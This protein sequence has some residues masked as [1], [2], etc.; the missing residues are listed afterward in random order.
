MVE[1]STLRKRNILKIFK[2]RLR[3]IRMRK[4]KD[5]F[6]IKPNL[7]LEDKQIIPDD[8]IKKIVGYF[9]EV[10]SLDNDQLL[11]ELNDLEK[12]DG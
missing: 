5:Q 1:I 10:L 4:V 11:N 8:A 3:M 2:V 9:G 7:V 6:P 12:K